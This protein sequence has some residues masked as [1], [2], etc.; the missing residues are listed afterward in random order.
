M[1]IITANNKKIISISKSEWIKIGEISGWIFST[2]Q[3]LPKVIDEVQFN[4]F[5][6]SLGYDLEG[7]GRATGSSHFK[8][9]NRYTNR[10]LTC[11]KETNDPYYFMLLMEIQ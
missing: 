10:I 3:G 1:K 6:S 11:V 9:K 2:A 4:K 8:F 5:L 7:R